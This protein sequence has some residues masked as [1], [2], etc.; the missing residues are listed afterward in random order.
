MNE[1]FARMLTTLFTKLCRQADR[2]LVIMVHS[3]LNR[4][5]MS[6]SYQNMSRAVKRVNSKS[7]LVSRRLRLRSL[8]LESTDPLNIMSTSPLTIDSIDPLTIV[9]TGPLT[10]GSTGPLTIGS[11]PPP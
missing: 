9:S 7:A 10:I 4:C 6:C 1:A 11:T 2:N 3:G 8:N 5:L